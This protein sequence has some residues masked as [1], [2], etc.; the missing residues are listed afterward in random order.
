MIQVE[1]FSPHEV[2]PLVRMWRESFEYGVGITDTNPLEAQISYFQNEIAPT[3]HVRLAKLGGQ[4][5]G[6]V[7]SNPES[8]NLLYVRVGF[9]RQG[10]GKQLL[11]LAKAESCGSLWLYT[12]ARNKVACTFY[13]SQG[14][15]VVQRGFEPFWQLKDVKFNWSRGDA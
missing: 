8:V 15:V 9:H 4:M 1:E 7:A 3:N 11:Q 13:E 5:V 12:F 10:I 6:V 2:E 14:F